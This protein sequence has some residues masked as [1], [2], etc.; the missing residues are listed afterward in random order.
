[1]LEESLGKWDEENLR[2][3]GAK[4]LELME[5]VLSPLRNLT[6]NVSMKVRGAVKDVIDAA[7]TSPDSLLVRS[8]RSAT[9]GPAR[10]KTL[11]PL[12]YPED[13]RA[14]DLEQ[15]LES[16]SLSQVARALCPVMK[17]PAWMTVRGGFGKACLAERRRRGRYTSDHPVHIP[18]PLLWIF[19]GPSTNQGGVSRRMYLQSQRESSWRGMEE[20]RQG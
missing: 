9:K 3:F 20:V 11:D 4:L 19:V 10:R 12:Q 5:P 15:A 16:L 17:Y 8:F 1:M 13:Q 7:V 14:S 2:R 6:H 18:K